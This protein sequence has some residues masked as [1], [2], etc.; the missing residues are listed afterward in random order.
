MIKVCRSDW[1]FCL[2]HPKLLLAHILFDLF[3]FIRKY[4]IY[5]TFKLCCDK[6]RLEHFFDGKLLKT[7]FCNEFYASFTEKQNIYSLKRQKNK[8]NTFSLIY[9]FYAFTFNV[10]KY[11]NLNL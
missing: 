10:T 1:H 6:I 3:Y 8:S 11:P 7:K 2:I 4:L 5:T 9:I